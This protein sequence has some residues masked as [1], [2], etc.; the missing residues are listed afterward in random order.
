M[1]EENEDYYINEDG[2]LVMTGR[3]LLKRGYCCGL[4]CRHCPYKYEKVP[5]PFKSE[6]LKARAQRNRMNKTQTKSQIKQCNK[7]QQS[8]E[9]K[10]VDIS[11]C[12]CY[13]IKLSPEAAQEIREKYDNCLCNDCLKEYEN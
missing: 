11:S 5:E 6:A 3:Y 8:F 2:L 13:T 10:A 7:C 1:I 12:H 4:A 9:C